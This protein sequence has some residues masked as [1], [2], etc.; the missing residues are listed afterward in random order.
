MV[1]RS[2]IAGSEGR[3][4]NIAAGMETIKRVEPLANPAS[5]LTRLAKTGM[6]LS[7]SVNS[8]VESSPGFTSS[9]MRI[10]KSNLGYSG[11]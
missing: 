9:S 8:S 4:A 1:P 10:L 5:T 3:Y 6:S 2:V 11:S 7:Q